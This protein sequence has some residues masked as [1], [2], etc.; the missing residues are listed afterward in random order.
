MSLDTNN[1][2][3]IKG[4]TPPPTQNPNPGQ[5]VFCTV[6]LPNFSRLLRCPHLHHR[7]PQCHAITVGATFLDTAS[8]DTTSSPP[9]PSTLSGADQ[10][11]AVLALPYSPTLWHNRLSGGS[12]HSPQPLAQPPPRQGSPLPFT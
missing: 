10:G 1:I 4:V 7:L 8:L 3:G 11:C 6:G 5:K 2:S 9:P 12:C